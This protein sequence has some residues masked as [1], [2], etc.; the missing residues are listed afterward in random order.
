[1]EVIQMVDLQGQYKKIKSEVDDAIQRVINEAGFINGPAV[2]N[3]QS[4]LAS[5]TGSKFV[6]GCANGTD[7]L[8]IA[9]MALDLKP[10]DE[11]IT[12]PFTFISTVEVIRLL[13]LKP[14][15]VDIIPDTFNM[16]VSQLK[17]AITERT[18][19]I[20]PVHLFGQCADMESILQIAQQYNLYVVEDACQAIGATVTFSDGTVRQAGTMGTIGCTSFFPS[21]NLGCYGDGGALFTQDETLAKKIKMIA[22]H[23]SAV[24]YHHDCVGVN[25]R[26]DAI[27]AA[28][29]SVKL[30]YLN[31]YTEAHRKAAAFYNHHLSRCSALEI[32]VTAPFT[33]HVYHQYTL[34]LLQ[35][36]RDQVQMELKSQGIPTAVY[37]PVPVHLNMGYRDLDYAEGSFPVTETLASQV[38]SLPMHTE[39]N[40]EQLSFIVENLLNAME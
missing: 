4:E 26:L 11:V 36:K 33:T 38:L 31:A 28:I 9:L 22:S 12:V 17:S 10:G 27:Q 15:F 24:K 14:V 30:K 37:Y 2:A 5:F 32:P 23:G 18:K 1:M 29:L 8:Q 35:P 25:S 21:K 34:K 19:A 6:V 20:V 7:A 40:E 13:G 3:F 16:D 39:L